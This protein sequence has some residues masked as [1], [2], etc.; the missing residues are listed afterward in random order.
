MKWRRN[1]LAL[2]LLAAIVLL[3]LVHPAWGE[4]DEPSTDADKAPPTETTPQSEDT[5]NTTVT[6]VPTSTS[7]GNGP[8][9]NGTEDAGRP[10]TEDDR[11]TGALSLTKILPPVLIIG[12][13]VAAV[14]LA[15]WYWRRRNHQIFV[16]AVRNDQPTASDFDDTM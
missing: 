1:T 6:P 9:T 15:L 13:I 3:M 16:E 5:K 11:K 10:G 7:D 12:L 2:W 4:N 14:A 8:A